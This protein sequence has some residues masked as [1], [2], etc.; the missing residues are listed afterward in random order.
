MNKKI[1]AIIL[2]RDGKGD[3]LLYLEYVDVEIQKAYEKQTFRFPF[4][5]WVRMARQDKKSESLKSRFGKKNSVVAYPNEKPKYEYRIRVS[6]QISKE[7]EYS[8]KIDYDI[9]KQDNTNDYKIEFFSELPNS[10]TGDLLLCVH[11]TF[12]QSELYKFNEDTE[13]IDQENKLTFQVKCHEIGEV[14]NFIF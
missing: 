6:P 7:T 14:F 10:K 4:D 12:G 13:S 1:S 2:S 3:E 8:I 11:G 5:G 9:K